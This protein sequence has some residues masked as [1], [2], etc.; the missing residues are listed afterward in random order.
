[1]QRARQSAAREP[2]EDAGE[3]ASRAVIDGDGGERGGEHDAFERDVHDA[4]SLGEDAAE[5]GAGVRHRRAERLREHRA[6]EDDGEGAH[7]G[8]AF[9]ERS[10]VRSRASA[11]ATPQMTTPE[12]T[13]M[14]SFGTCALIARPPCWSVPK[15]S[16]AAMR[17]N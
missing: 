6:R 2:R 13:S 16:A 10:V 15:S 9:G 4:A 7:A 1:M 3:R 14:T 12:M 5:R 17:P 11:S 8:F